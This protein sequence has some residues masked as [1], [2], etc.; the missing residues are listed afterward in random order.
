MATITKNVAGVDVAK[1]NLEVYLLPSGQSLTVPNTKLG[2]KKML[3]I[4][5]KHDIKRVVFESTGGYEKL[6]FD[7][8]EKANLNPWRVEPRRIDRKSVV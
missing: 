7:T 5:K 6:L 1:A 4:L 3:P 8:T 2:I